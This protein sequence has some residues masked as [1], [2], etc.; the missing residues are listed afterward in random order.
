MPL[1]VKGLRLFHK[2][3]VAHIKSAGP[4]PDLQNKTTWMPRGTAPVQQ[5][6]PWR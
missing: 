4:L 1:N 6:A 3:I 2:I 5:T